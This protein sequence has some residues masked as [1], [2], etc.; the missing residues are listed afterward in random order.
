MRDVLIRLPY[1]VPEVPRKRLSQSRRAAEPRPR[2]RK[3]SM[4]SSAPSAA[5][6]A[7][8]KPSCKR[9]RD[10]LAIGLRYVIRRS[11]MRDW[12]PAGPRRR[13]WAVD[14]AAVTV[15]VTVTVTVQHPATARSRSGRPAVGQP[16]R[17]WS[18]WMEARNG[19]RT[20]FPLIVGFSCR[21]AGNLGTRPA[22]GEGR[23]PSVG[24]E[25][26]QRYGGGR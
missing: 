10:L 7:N 1:L 3:T 25:A 19:P 23:G 17:G 6:R 15:T 4:S 22:P 18:L 9:R 21:P 14:R 20:L 16:R 13:P 2:A 11:T 5:L 26:V 8:L 24:C 12:L